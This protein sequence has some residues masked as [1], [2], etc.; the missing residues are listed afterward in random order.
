MPNR[1]QAVARLIDIFD[2]EDEIDLVGFHPREIGQ[3]FFVEHVEFGREW[4]NGVYEGEFVNTWICPQ[5]SGTAGLEGVH[6]EVLFFIDKSIENLL[7]DWRAQ[8]EEE[9]VHEEE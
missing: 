3:L 9:D 2:E 4:W 7:E 5:R 8:A 6:Y 1:P